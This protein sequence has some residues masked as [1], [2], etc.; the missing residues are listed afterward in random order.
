M[1]TS[2]LASWLRLTSP[3]RSRSTCSMRPKLVLRQAQRPCDAGRFGAAVPGDDDG[4]ARTD[5]PV[6]L[7]HR[8]FEVGPDR[9]VS[10]RDHRSTLA[11]GRPVRSA[12]PRLEPNP[13]GAHGLPVVPPGLVAHL[14][15]RVDSTDARGV[16]A[17]GE[18]PDQTA[19]PVADLEDVVAGLHAENADHVV[20]LVGPQHEP[21]GQPAEPAARMSERVVGRGIEDPGRGCGAMSP[22]WHFKPG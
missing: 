11:S 18:Q 19:R 12:V 16:G 13:A 8:G 20:L 6:Q 3:K 1:N 22:R 21:A 14:R 9:D 5:D 7:A 17:F 2:R 15:R 4:A 10:H